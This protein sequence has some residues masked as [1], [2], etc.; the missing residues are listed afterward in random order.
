MSFFDNESINEEH[1]RDCAFQS[2][3]AI[4]ESVSIA[5]K[6]PQPITYEHALDLISDLDPIL[7]T[8]ISKLL[9]N[10]NE[11]DTVK[12]FKEKAEALSTP[13][14][15]IEPIDLINDEI[16]EHQI[17]QKKSKDKKFITKR[18]L[19]LAGAREYF[20]P[21]EISEH[22]I[23]SGDF[24][25]AD[26]SG[27]F[28]K[29]IYVNDSY[30]DYGLPNSNILRLRLL[31]PDQ[32]ESILGVDLIYEIFDLEKE[33]VR[34]AHLQYKTWNT[35]VLYLT[36]ERMNNQIQKMENNLCNSGFCKDQD[37]EKYSQ[38]YRLPYC[39]AF[40]RPTSKLQSSESK[41]V[42]TGMHIPIC[43][44]RKLQDTD[45]KL[46]K[47]NIIERSISSKNFE[48]LFND[49]LLGSRWI[50]IDSL[51]KFYESHGLNSLT[52]KVRIHAQEFIN[53]RKEK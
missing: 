13:D 6:L 11:S 46:T 53:N 28:S 31:H 29:P 5:R 50:S 23:L 26:R 18:I 10:K 30:K 42:S 12:Y 44:V 7:Y 35:N 4:R 39:C 2:L 15:K 51:D 21:R 41:L 22:K 40:L 1:R 47:Q 14:Q 34:F 43:E 9:S 27:Y 25:L 37:G 33:Q 52:D 8:Q 49:N 19:E 20:M 36:D 17:L 48:D 45:K 24:Y 3:I 16:F 38:L 32:A